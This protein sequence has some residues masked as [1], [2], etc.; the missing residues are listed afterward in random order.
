MLSIF[1]PKKQN[2]FYVFETEDRL[3]TVQFTDLDTKPI[4]DICACSC[5]C[6]EPKPRPWDIILK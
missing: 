2:D 3:E 4:C 6:N 1:K 5:D